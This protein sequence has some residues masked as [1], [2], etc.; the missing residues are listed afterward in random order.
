MDLIA[1]CLRILGS[2]HN[3]III[4]GQVISDRD[5]FFDWQIENNII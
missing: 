4:D 1:F 3:Q 5:D 2:E